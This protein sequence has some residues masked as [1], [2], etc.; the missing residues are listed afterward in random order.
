MVRSHTIHNSIR[1]TIA[2]RRRPLISI[3]EEHVSH[4]ALPPSSAFSWRMVRIVSHLA[5]SK[6]N[7]E[8]QAEKPRRESMKNIIGQTEQGKARESSLQHVTK[9]TAERNLKRTRSKLDDDKCE[10]DSNMSS[11]KRTRAQ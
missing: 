6:R 11:I 1:G 8:N 7:E 2:K 4:A 10:P 9:A 5:L 3:D